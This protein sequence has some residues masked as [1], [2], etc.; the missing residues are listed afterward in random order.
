MLQ[1]ALDEGVTPLQPAKLGDAQVSTLVDFLLTLTDP[2][3][4]D[5]ACLAPWMP[6]DD[7]TDPDG[8]RLLVH[9]LP[10]E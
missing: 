7:E 8:H 6:A 2:C 9:A 1:D 5:A 10:G 3:V 4:K